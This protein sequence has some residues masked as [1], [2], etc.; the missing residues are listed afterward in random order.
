MPIVPVSVRGTTFYGHTTRTIPRKSVNTEA[1]TIRL[2]S[3]W[4]GLDVV[5]FWKNSVIEEPVTRQL[6]DPAQPH[7]I[8]WE[9]LS[10]IG[11]L[12]MGLVGLDGGETVKPTI[13]LLYGYVVEGV[14]PDVGSGS[15]PPTPNYLQQMVALAEAAANAA[16]AA[17][18]TADNLQAAA[19]AGEFDGDTG[20]VG[21]QGPAGPKGP[22]GE[23]GPQGP[24]GPEGP[25]GPQGP[26]GDTGDV[27]PQGPPGNTGPQGPAGPQGEQGPKGDTGDVGPQGPKG[28]TGPQG[29]QGPAGPQG[30]EGPAG[31]KIDDSTLGRDT[32]WSSRMIV[33]SLAP[34]FEASGPVVTCNPVSGYPL[35]VVS[36]IKYVQAGG[37]DPSPDNV[38]PISGYTEATVKITGKNL[39]DI[40]KIENVS[41]VVNNGDGTIT[42]TTSP[43]DAVA[44]TKRTLRELVGDLPQ[45]DYYLNAT[46][47]GS[48]KMIYLTGVNTTWTFGRVREITS[49]V[50][51]SKVAFY[52]SG[53]NTTATISD[54]Y[55]SPAALQGPYVPYRAD[56]KTVSVVFKDAVYGGQLNWT[57]G[58]LTIDWV[59]YVAT[60][61]ENPSFGQE[62]QTVKR[63]CFAPQAPTLGN[64]GRSSI[65]CDKLK[66]LSTGSQDAV[67]CICTGSN[68]I[69][70][71]LPKDTVPDADAV[72]EWLRT[73]QPEFV[74]QTSK[75]SSIQLEP[76]DIKSFSGINT[77]FSNSGDITVSGRSASASDKVLLSEKTTKEVSTFT[78]TEGL[79]GVKT[80]RAVLGT[81][82]AASNASYLKIIFYIADKQYL[83]MPF[84]SAPRTLPTQI[85]IKLSIKDSGIAELN[86]SGGSNQSDLYT[87]RVY[88][89][90]GNVANVFS[91]FKIP[92]YSSIDSFSIQAYDTVFPKG[93]NILIAGEGV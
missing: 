74:Y 2:D 36:Q 30:P 19:E 73:N 6:D 52:A 70:V 11:D 21:P 83:V 4:D 16:K 59:K 67:G 76:K 71:L 22:Q 72:K 58:E 64:S 54:I 46:T 37:G 10:E 90:V 18:E 66:T 84:A 25:Q 91:Q 38:R 41:G 35:S 24:A 39:F 85:S 57:T 17:K 5:V 55:L 15:Q 28:D 63:W 53:A 80:I 89:P 78:V 33:D 79:E 32:T 51:A 77:L 42:V 12:R 47:T 87:P 92:Q 29:E 61:N 69:S 88:N 50:L 82:S 27:G 86:V 49:E 81:P 9:V 65:V 14:D 43:G 26:K 48:G 45:G 68:L 3:S 75:P 93:T 56:S 13:W 62:N 31:G 7:T 8:P 1:V 34:S 40:S 44:Y 60:G 20:P 23:V